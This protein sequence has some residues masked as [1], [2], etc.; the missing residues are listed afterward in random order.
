MFFKWSF[1][2]FFWGFTHVEG[3]WDQNFKDEKFNGKTKLK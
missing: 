3:N 2:F 1:I